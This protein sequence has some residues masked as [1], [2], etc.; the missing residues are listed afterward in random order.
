MPIHV[1]VQPEDREKEIIATLKKMISMKEKI[2]ELSSG[3]RSCASDLLQQ[4][5]AVLVGACITG[6]I[7]LFVHSLESEVLGSV[8]EM[9][10][11][12]QLTVVVRDLFRCLTKD[13]NLTVEVEIVAEMSEECEEGFADNG[14]RCCTPIYLCLVTATSARFGTGVRVSHANV[15]VE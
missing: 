6:S 15:L 9:Y 4:L 13:G 7:T 5:Q 1:T 3:E 14:M 8:R 2:E 12:G 11:T 10:N